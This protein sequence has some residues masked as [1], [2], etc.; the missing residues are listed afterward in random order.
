MTRES[1]CL[2][3]CRRG[4]EPHIEQ[5]TLEYL[6]KND[7]VRLQIEALRDILGRD[8]RLRDYPKVLGRPGLAVWSAESACVVG[9]LHE[10]GGYRALTDAEVAA[11]VGDLR[12]RP[13]QPML[14]CRR[15]ECRVR[16]GD[17]A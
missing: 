14:A 7:R 9:A 8:F 4:V 12:Q 5:L 3:S 16:G 2:V 17:S 10:R 1:I 15:Q 13:E 11:V 6:D